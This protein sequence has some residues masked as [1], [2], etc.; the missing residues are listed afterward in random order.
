M[1]RKISIVL[2]SL[3]FAVSCSDDD[4][5]SNNTGVPDEVDLSESFFYRIDLTDRSDDTFKVRMYVDNLTDANKVYQFPA[6]VPGVYDIFDIGRFVVNFKAFDENQNELTVT[7]ISTNQWE[8][9]DPLATRVIEFEVKETFDTP[10]EEHQL[11][12]MGGTSMENDHVLL[13]AFDVLGYPTGLKERDF[14]LDVDYP[15]GW[16]IAT[17]L[18][19]TNGGLYYAED[20]DKFVDSP[21][22]VGDITVASVL[23]DGA[24]INVNTY[25]E[26][27]QISAGQVLNDVEQVLEDASAF[28]KGLP[29]DHY[30]FIYFFH[31]APGAGALEHSYSSVYVLNDRPYTPSYG[32][33]IRD[34]SAHEFFHIVTP[35]NIHSEIIEDFN[36]AVPTASQHLW[37]Y[38]GVTEWASLMMQYRN[39]SYTTPGILNEFRFKKIYAD[40]YNQSMSL[41]V[42]SQTCYTPEGGSQFGN[43]Y[44]K[45]ALVAALLDIRLLELS[46]GQKGLRELILEL[47]DTYGPNNAFSEEN[48][49]DDLVDRTYPEIADFIDLYI[50]GT[51]PLPMEEYFNKIG[52]DFIPETNSL[53]EMGVKTS[54][55]QL[56]FDKWKVNL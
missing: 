21:I 29:V 10:V 44:Q 54:Q 4:S 42:M 41:T 3:I 47:I 17:S 49:F 39:G 35:L 18:P 15:S 24:K 9:S 13:N 34:I 25:S 26:G 28:L 48:F 52:V 56:L 11:Y 32:S 6:T 27:D 12:Q 45:G 33:G 16:K 37:L 19:K 40:S 2:I 20:Y 43:V 5:T 55:Q 53:N 38:E 46:N 7:N 30:N 36:F 51:A 8:L 31:N 50:E 1:F 23:I 14:Y 22:I